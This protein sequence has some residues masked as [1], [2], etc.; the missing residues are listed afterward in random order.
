MIREKPV[1]TALINIFLY[2][3]NN[4]TWPIGPFC[5]FGKF[6]SKDQIFDLDEKLTYHPL[7]ISI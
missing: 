1:F 3:Q 5:K 6:Y 7:R 2:T 4:K